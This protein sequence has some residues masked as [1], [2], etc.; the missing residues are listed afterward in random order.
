MTKQVK[1]IYEFGP[2]HLDATEHV[3]R[4]NGQEIVLT[5]KPYEV[6]LILIEN[7]G[8]IVEREAIM[9]KCWPN[10]SVED[11]N[12]TQHISDLREILREGGDSYEYIETIPRRGYRFTATVKEIVGGLENYN[13]TRNPVP[14]RSEG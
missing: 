1:H 7:S 14:L 4:K 3:L 10:T 8:H 11:S 9:K 5:P 12:I 2:F 6:L 13:S